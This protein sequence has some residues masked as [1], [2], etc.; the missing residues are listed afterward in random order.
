VRSLEA[1]IEE[2]LGWGGLE[3]AAALAQLLRAEGA[4]PALAAWMSA[5]LAL[6]SEKPHDAL[7][8]LTPW[9]P[10]RGEPPEVAC[11]LWLASAE[12]LARLGRYALA[13]GHLVHAAVPA[14][15][16]DAPALR[17]H[18][19][20]VRIL[21][22]DPPPPEQLEACLALLEPPHR[23]CLLAEMARAHEAR[24]AGAEAEA[25]WR[26][27][28][29]LAPE[30]SGARAE[31]CLHL[32]RLA[33][34][35]GDVAEA[36]GHFEVC[37]SAPPCGSHQAEAALRK[38]LALLDLGRREEAV[39]LSGE[40]VPLPERLRPLA[41][42]VAQE[43]GGGG[44]RAADE[45]RAGRLLR[46]GLGA[47]DAGNVR[48]ARAWLTEALHQAE[49]EGHADARS[50]ALEALT[51]L[52]ALAGD[53]AR[54]REMHEAHLRIRDHSGTGEPCD[55]GQDLL[56]WL[57]AGA[58]RRGEAGRALEHLE[59]R[60]ARGLAAMGW[61]PEA[62]AP[63]AWD[64]WL[65]SRGR[66][67]TSAAPHLASLAELQ[68]ALAPG[69]AF[70]SLAVVGG[71]A[72]LFACWPREARVVPLGGLASLQALRSAVRE[73]VARCAAGHPV[74]RQPLEDALADVGE[75]PLGAALWSILAE[76]KSRMLLWSPEG[77]GLG[78]PIAALRR[79]GHLLIESCSLAHAPSA[80]L[81]VH[82]ERN[83]AARVWGRAYILGDSAESTAAA[84]SFWRSRTLQGKQASLAALDS[85]L[86]TAK[87]V[88]LACSAL[89]GKAGALPAL[90]LPS[91]EEWEPS[92]G[93]AEAAEG[94]PLLV[95]HGWHPES[96]PL[97]RGDEAP[98]LAA[99]LL[100]GGALSVL[101]PLWPVA[102]REASELLTAF[103]R[104]RITSAPADALALA[105]RELAHRSPLAWGGFA[106][107]G[108]P[109]ALP[110]PR[111][112][113]WLAAW[114]LRARHHHR[115]PCPGLAPSSA[116]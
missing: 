86:S 111:G 24:G 18:E 47:D 50:R 12:A 76:S 65:R 10:P 11:R 32:G 33:H 90:T 82:H 48:D 46:L 102:S 30:G 13:R 98:T 72:W 31:A 28:L 93:S 14:G 70:A 9:I 36:L 97:W 112:L 38:A 58:C 62:G 64:A 71:E 78:V 51:R 1:E 40:T 22:G 77:P 37:L 43:L 45:S 88:H 63:S 19:L 35:R 42:Q 87:C 73:Q 53:E 56:G 69:Q 80:S 109:S 79:G 34:L 114:W 106:L 116:G 27:L 26:R 49:A 101:A 59:L 41:A 91:G 85:A 96:A 115:F 6:A 57:L 99:A 108:C 15:P 84:A 2:S 21:L 54:A 16:L 94:L 5:R 110:P 83:A 60:R 55:G 68:S 4:S 100:A 95:V 81:T 67:A 8:C 39:R 104:H 113:A 20:R 89:R 66:P 74:D 25:C 44:H 23:A 61:A 103:H 52:T 29:A 7:A 107:F 92:M 17:M 105:Q 75:G 3:R